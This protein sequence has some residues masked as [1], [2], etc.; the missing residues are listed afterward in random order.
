MSKKGSPKTVAAI[1]ERM[2]H[3][4]FNMFSLSCFG[5]PYDILRF[6]LFLPFFF[7]LR[8]VW[9]EDFLYTNYLWPGC[10][11]GRCRVENLCTMI[12]ST[13]QMFHICNAHIL[14]L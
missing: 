13:L 9:V 10:W 12:L 2:F 6:I 4:C 7:T 11:I 8:F 1:L 14:M 3:Y 5:N